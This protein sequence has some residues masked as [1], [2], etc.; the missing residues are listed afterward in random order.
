[1]FNT[2]IDLILAIISGLTKGFCTVFILYFILSYLNVVVNNLDPSWVCP[3][4]N[5]FHF[6]K[7]VLTKSFKGDIIKIQ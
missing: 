3:S 5:L 6:F 2:K 1:M 4:W 7:Q